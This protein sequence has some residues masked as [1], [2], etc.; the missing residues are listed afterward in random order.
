[1]SH[2][3]P[4]LAVPRSPTPPLAAG[5]ART[6]DLDVTTIDGKTINL[7][8]LYGNK[9]IYLKF[10]ATWCGP[11]IA[12]MPHVTELQKEY[13]TLLWNMLPT[14]KRL[15]KLRETL[16]SELESNTILPKSMSDT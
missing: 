2:P 4:P 16:S 13:V 14:L 5:G 7:S 15:N 6:F 10:W 12:S 9:P 1:M 8:K 3:A 11:C